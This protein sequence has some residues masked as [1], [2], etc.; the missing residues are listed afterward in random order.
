MAVLSYT[1]PLEFRIFSSDLSTGISYTEACDF[2]IYL[3]YL[4]EFRILRIRSLQIHDILS[5][6]FRI[7][8]IPVLDFR[9]HW[10]LVYWDTGLSYTV[11]YLIYILE[12]CILNHWTLLTG[13]EWNRFVPKLFWW[14]C[15]NKFFSK[16]HIFKLSTNEKK[17]INCWYFYMF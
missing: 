13:P 15:D 8:L 4:L 12:F 5:L 6:D 11:I 14:D 3:I 10:N 9:I 7:C 1:E 2:R 16:M 17:W